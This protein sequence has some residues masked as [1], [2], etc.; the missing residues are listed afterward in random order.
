[1]RE[2]LRLNTKDVR[3]Q[4]GFQGALATIK[5]LYDKE[6]LRPPPRITSNLA[7]GQSHIPP[8]IAPVP[9]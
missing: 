3:F 7:E 9:Y 5:P 4:K 2:L 6:R 8:L 1:M